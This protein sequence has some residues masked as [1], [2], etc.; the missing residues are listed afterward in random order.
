MNTSGGHSWSSIPDGSGGYTA[1]DQSSWQA[2]LS[3]SQELLASGGS[4]WLNLAG[5]RH[6]LLAV[7]HETESARLNLVLDVTEKYYGV[8][9]AIGHMESAETACLKSSQLF[10]RTQSRY[11]LGA[12]TNLEMIQAEVQMNRDLL[13]LSQKETALI[14]AYIQLYEAASVL[15]SEHTV[16]SAAVL[17]PVSRDAAENY[18]LDISSNP[19]YLASK[20]RLRTSELSADASSRSYW[21]S[22]SAGGSWTW[23]N[24][25]PEFDNFGNED[26]WSIS[27]S[28]NWTLFD[29]FS[30]ESIIQSRR[31]A[32]ISVGAGLESLENSLL[33]SVILARNNLLGGIDSYQLAQLVLEQ[34]REQLRLSE[35]SYSLG[36]ITLAE[37]LDAET[38]Y[39]QA[40]ASLVSARVECLISEA[41]LLVLLGRTPRLGE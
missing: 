6:S 8:I 36:S 38:E 9:E 17:M 15:V 22:L 37:L 33:S 39:T 18:N 10:D 32:V 3:F 1:S 29:G 35:Q 40:E 21:P 5:S 31:S 19:S 16:N 30:R 24:D 26:S 27:A 4:S 7:Q 23:S 2:S 20:E 34:T 14:A 41:R 11:E 28:L 13:T 25:E 12:V